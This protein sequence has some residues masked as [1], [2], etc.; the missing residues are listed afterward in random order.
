MNPTLMTGSMIVTIALI[1]Y[2]IAILTE[3][4]IHIITKKVLT[5]LTIGIIL[6]ITATTFMI[7]GS[8]NSPFTV[9]GFIGYSALTFMLIDTILI[10]RFRFNNGLNAKV[11][12]GIHLYS[13]VAYIWWVCAYFTGGIIAMII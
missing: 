13:R 8:T 4:K 6:D 7:I 2:S 12:N 9:H 1:A 5:F 10:W 3:Q 11:T